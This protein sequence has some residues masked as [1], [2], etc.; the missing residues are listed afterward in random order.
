MKNEN[1]NVDTQPKVGLD[2]DITLVG[3]NGDNPI[4][5]KVDTGAEEC[6][7]HAEDLTEDGD[8]VSGSGS[9]SFTFGEYKYKMAVH[10]HQ[11]VSSADGGTTLR[12]TI[13]LG[14]RIGED[15]IPDVI[16]NLNDR[17]SMEYPILLGTTFLRTARLVV[18]PNM[19]EAIEITF[20]DDPHPEVDNNKNVDVTTDVGDNISSELDLKALAFWYNANKSKTICQLL[21]ELINS[22]IDEKN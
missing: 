18:D 19:S 6:S 10:G 8:S 17:S 5:A 7:L 11:S 15:Y 20:A 3:I 14:V 2:L 16:F 1:D 22:G 9:V 13:K 4:R 12:P 21:T